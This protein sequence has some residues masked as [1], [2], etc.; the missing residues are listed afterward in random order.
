V[1]QEAHRYPL[2]HTLP[3]GRP[4]L[5]AEGTAYVCEGG[6]IHRQ[7]LDGTTLPDLE[8]PVEPN[9]WGVKQRADGTIYYLSQH[10]T[11]VAVKDGA[12]QFE[13]DVGHREGC[14]AAEPGGNYL[15]CANRTVRRLS[16]SGETLARWDYPLD[17]STGLQDVLPGRDGAFFTWASDGAVRGHSSAGAVEWTR[18]L[19][20]NCGNHASIQLSR[21]GTRL[22]VN[23]LHKQLVGLDAATGQPTFDYP[24]GKEEGYWSCS[25]WVELEDGH[26]L[27]LT[28]GGQLLRFDATGQEVDRVRTG[29]QWGQINGSVPVVERAGDYLCVMPSVGSFQ[30]YSLD[31]LKVAEYLC[32]NVFG[33]AAYYHSVGIRDNRVV[34]L[35][36][37][38]DL[39]RVDLPSV[40][41]APLDG[42][43]VGLGETPTLLLIGGVRVKKRG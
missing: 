27:I 19:P 11:A 42:A 34:L 16:P 22:Y 1:P 28:E 32:S 20:R 31:G 9:V 40:K 43:P 7:A 39:A 36:G 13:V 21:D 4:W 25:D 2:R 14:I 10:G 37:S 15:V 24:L 12:R 18:A 33:G 3:R 30:I 17:D 23:G 26:R 8:L 5:D 35:P 6:R 41:E 29:R 38:F